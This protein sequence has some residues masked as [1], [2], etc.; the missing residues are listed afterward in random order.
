MGGGLKR[1]SGE[2]LW[3]HS[4]MKSNLI[5]ITVAAA[6]ITTT[7]RIIQ[8]PYSSVAPPNPNSPQPPSAV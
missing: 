1:V 5:V 7:V 3:R 2:Q 6:L 8:P 4:Q